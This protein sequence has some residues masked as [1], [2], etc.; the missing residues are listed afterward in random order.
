MPPRIRGD[1]EEGFSGL[2]RYNIMG[3]VLYLD[4]AYFWL[5]GKHYIQGF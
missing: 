1:F 2:L 5:G 3:N 4:V